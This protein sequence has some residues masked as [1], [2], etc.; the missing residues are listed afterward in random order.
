MSTLTERKKTKSRS[1]SRSK[2]APIGGAEEAL[3]FAEEPETETEYIAIDFMDR[4]FRFEKPENNS[5]FYESLSIN[6]DKIQESHNTILNKFKE[7]VP[8]QQ[9]SSEEMETYIDQFKSG[10]D[11]KS[12]SIKEILIEYYSIYINYFVENYKDRNID[13][14]ITQF[15]LDFEQLPPIIIDENVKA[16]LENTM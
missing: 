11:L 15:Y 7:L 4:R 5:E 3:D 2:K 13:K 9:Q 8:P 1:R 16:L 14:N 10:V 12:K 6:T